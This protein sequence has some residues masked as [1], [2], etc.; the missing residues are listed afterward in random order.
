MP[1]GD[2]PLVGVAS[3]ML[4]QRRTRRPFAPVPMGL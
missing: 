4:S 1:S 2:G 3:F